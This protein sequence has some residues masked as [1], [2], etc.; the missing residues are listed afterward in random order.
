MPLAFCWRKVIKKDVISIS[1]GVIAFL[2]ARNV[3]INTRSRPFFPR[4]WVGRLG[5]GLIISHNALQLHST[6]KT[7]HDH[8]AIIYS[9][10]TRVMHFSSAYNFYG[11]NVM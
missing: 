1:D 10:Y 4:E 11:I 3:L 9:Y 5:T 8:L 7:F 2:G 6:Q